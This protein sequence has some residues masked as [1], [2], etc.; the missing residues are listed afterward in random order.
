MTF[1]FEAFCGNHDEPGV[2]LLY[3]I[4]DKLELSIGSDT[5]ALESGDAI[6]FD[7]AVG[8]NYGRVGKQPCSA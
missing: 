6:Y 4:R 5:H 3:L 8:H 2:A 1:A 7:S